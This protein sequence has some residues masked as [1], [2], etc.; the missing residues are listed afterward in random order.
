MRRRDQPCSTS[1]QAQFKLPVGDEKAIQG[2]FVV[3]KRK[4]VRNNDCQC[5]MASVLR[6]L[7]DFVIAS[8]IP[9]SKDLQETGEGRDVNFAALFNR[10]RNG[11]FLSRF[12]A[13]RGCDLELGFRGVGVQ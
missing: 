8:N 9:T 11:H 12:R 5:G 7:L 3:Q 6:D 1:H 13:L 4:D 10:P 2:T